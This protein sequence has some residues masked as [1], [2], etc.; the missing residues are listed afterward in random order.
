VGIGKRLKVPD[1]FFTLSNSIGYQRYELNEWDYFIFQNGTS[2]NLS[3]T[4]TLARNS[5][6]QIIYPRIGSS[7]SLTL[8]LTPPYSLFKGENF[9]ELSANE[10]KAFND[11]N[12]LTIQRNEAAGYIVDARKPIYPEDMENAAK[13]KWIEYHKWK[14]KGSWYLKIWKDLVL[15]TNTEFGYLGYYNE[16]IGYSPFGKFKLGGDGMSGY[17]LYG[18]DN[19]SL[20][21]YENS[22]LTPRNEQNMED[23]NVYEKINFELRYPISLKPQAVIYVLGFVEAGNAWT[24]MDKFNPFDI[25]RSA[26]IGLRAFLP[27][28]G[29][30][31]IDWGYGFDEIPNDPNANGSQ[32]HFVIGQQ[33]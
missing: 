26:G 23:G 20:R 29:L 27:M 12:D 6:D 19:I 25:K 28:F 4:T 31:G 7:F 8:Q 30:L 24:D 18:V 11:R 9:W 22:A 5:T 17:S 33:F 13:Y 3:L 1:D 21:G 15:A 16:N 32:F 10:V 2:N 14:Y